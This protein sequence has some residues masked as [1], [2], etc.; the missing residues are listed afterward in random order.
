[1]NTSYWSMNEKRIMLLTAVGEILANISAG[2]YLLA[3]S[4]HFVYIC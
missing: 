1:M 2:M 3:S 4:I